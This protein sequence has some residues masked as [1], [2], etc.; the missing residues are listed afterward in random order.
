VECVPQESQRHPIAIVI[1]PPVPVLDASPASW[2]TVADKRSSEGNTA[3]RLAAEH[4]RNI[5]SVVGTLSSAR[6]VSTVVIAIPWTPHPRW[7][8]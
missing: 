8:T 4:V 6:A 2:M 5:V 3:S 7:T 1:L